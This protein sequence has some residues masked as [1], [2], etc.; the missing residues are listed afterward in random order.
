MEILIKNRILI[1]ILVVISEKK[2]LDF[3]SGYIRGEGGIRTL[4]RL[5]NLRLV[6]SEFLSA[7][8]APLQ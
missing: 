8:Q 5:L 6:S 4:G 2:C 3:C 1:T 7:T